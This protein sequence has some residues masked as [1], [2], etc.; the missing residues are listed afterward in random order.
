MLAAASGP[1]PRNNAKF[2]ASAAAISKSV[3]PVN[4]APPAG[5]T[6]RCKDG[7]YLSGAP[8]ADRC[9]NNG[10]VATVFPAK[11]GLTAPR[12]QAQRKQP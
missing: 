10:G 11:G 8:S 5:T 6:M 1:P 9:A 3:V 4:S 12:P 2:A 7:S